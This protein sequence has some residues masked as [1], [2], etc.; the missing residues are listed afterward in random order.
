MKHQLTR[1]EVVMADE[2]V[3]HAV[4]LARAHGAGGVRDRDAYALVGLDQGGDQAGLAGA[5]RGRND[6]EGAAAVV[7]GRGGLTRCSVL[8][9]ASV[10]SVPSG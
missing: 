6:I 5:R 4:L 2:V 8:V 10:R 1:I 9:H 3:V 7:H